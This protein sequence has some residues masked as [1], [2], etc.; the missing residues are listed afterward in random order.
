MKTHKIDQLPPLLNALS[1]QIPSGA[2]VL[3]LGCGDGELLKILK[4][5]KNATVQGIEIDLENINACIANGVP[6][7]QGDLNDGLGDFPD[8]A[9][10]VVILSETMQV[11]KSPD[12]LL[13]EIA[14]IS[15]LAIIGIINI[16][17]WKS[18][19][20]LFF[21]GKMPINKS[22]PH[23]WYNTPNI[24]L[25]TIKDFKALCSTLGLK[26]EAEIA[27]NH[28]FPLFNKVLPNL[29][30]QKSLFIVRPQALLKKINP[31]L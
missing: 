10:D 27:I 29:F 26:I 6:V 19:A 7:I 17:Y 21:Q 30:A 18:R 13:I 12:Q 5:Q 11:V 25:G 20:Q 28:D 24:H 9:F 2:N 22:L 4:Q 14:R 3:D 8:Q 1:K 15:K 23:Q 31:P 16:G